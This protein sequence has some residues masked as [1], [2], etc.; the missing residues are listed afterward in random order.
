MAVTSGGVAVPEEEC[1]SAGNSSFLRRLHLGGW[2]TRSPEDPV[3][4]WLGIRGKRPVP[5]LPGWQVGEHGQCRC[6]LWPSRQ[7]GTRRRTGS[8]EDPPAV[9]QH[10]RVDQD[11]VL[12]DQLIGQQRPD[13]LRAAVDL[14]F[15]ARQ[16]AARKSA[17]PRRNASAAANRAPMISAMSSSALGTSQPPCPNSP[18]ESSSG[19]PGPWMTPSMVTKGGSSQPHQCLLAIA[20]CPASG[21]AADLAPQ[22]GGRACRSARGLAAW[23]SSGRSAHRPGQNGAQPGLPRPCWW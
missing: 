19:A 6:A 22:P 12:V 9:S 1:W 4:F 13:E 8:S 20:L 3:P 16:P 2:R 7:A 18:L 5:W 15:S 23:A 17:A 21:D 14:Q 11:L 10:D